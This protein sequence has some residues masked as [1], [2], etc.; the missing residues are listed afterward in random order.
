MQ[1]CPLPVEVVCTHGH[2][3]YACSE[4]L[5]AGLGAVVLQRAR[6]S[7]KPE[8]LQKANLGGDDRDR[9]WV[10]G[11]HISRVKVSRRPRVDCLGAVNCGRLD[12]RE[13]VECRAF[14]HLAGETRGPASKN[15]T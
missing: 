13:L 15:E 12:A 5:L 9:G 11:F 8:P 6:Y 4:E 2:I 10:L 1:K 14:G 7:V 3:A